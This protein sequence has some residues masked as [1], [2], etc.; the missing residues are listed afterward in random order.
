M[1]GLARKH[2]VYSAIRVTKLS[3][4]RPFVVMV[5]HAASSAPR[6]SD[7]PKNP[8]FGDTPSFIHDFFPQLAHMA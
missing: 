2:F 1:S 5:V 7:T 4:C 3:L 6:E 8:S